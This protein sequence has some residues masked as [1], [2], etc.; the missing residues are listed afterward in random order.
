MREDSAKRSTPQTSASPVQS[1]HTTKPSPTL[2]SRPAVRSDIRSGTREES[3]QISG[4]VVAPTQSSHT[5]K[6]SSLFPPRRTASSDHL[7]KS[8][9]PTKSPT[10]TVIPP[11]ARQLPFHERR[12]RPTLVYTRC[13]TRKVY[14]V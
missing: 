14:Q 13:H 11:P 1:S 6:K 3:T 7:P 9:D 12:V 8:G 2:S 4:T 5:T 10:D